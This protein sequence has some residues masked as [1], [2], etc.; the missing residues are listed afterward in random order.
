MRV[1]SLFIYIN[2]INQIFAFFKFCS[3][4]KSSVGRSS[5]TFIRDLFY[6]ILKPKEGEAGGIYMDADRAR[7]IL[8]DLYNGI[9]PE[10]GETLPED[11]VC[12]SLRVASAL[13]IAIRAIEGVKLGVP[14]IQKYPRQRKRI[15]Y[16]REKNGLRK[17]SSALGNSGTRWTKEEKDM[18]IALYEKEESYQKIGKELRRTPFEVEEKLKMMGY[19][20][21]KVD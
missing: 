4:S 8:M 2:I 12:N 5:D 9:N 18:L 19:S 10:T 11:H 13:R 15:A 16:E 3:R 6:G 7:R 1:I 14:E 21:K 20:H 17:T